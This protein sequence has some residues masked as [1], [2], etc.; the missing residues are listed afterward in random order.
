MKAGCL[1]LLL[2]AAS[3]GTA[4]AADGGPAPA[5][6]PARTAAGLASQ[7]GAAAA[8]R[9]R[10]LSRRCRRARHRNRKR[11]GFSPSPARCPRDRTA[12][13][14]RAHPPKD[15]N[16]HVANGP[17]D[18]PESGGPD[19]AEGDS[20]EE[21][22]IHIPTGLFVPH[23]H[24]PLDPPAKGAEE[25]PVDGKRPLAAASVIGDMAVPR[26]RSIR[27]SG[28][29]SLADSDGGE[30][31]IATNGKVVLFTSNDGDAL[32]TDGG[33]T[34]KYLDPETIFPTAAGGFCCDQVVAYVPRR[35]RWVWVL[36]YWSGRDGTFNKYAP[37]VIR[38]ATATTAQVINSSATAWTYYD[39]VPASF[40]LKK[41]RLSRYFPNLDRPHVTFTRGNA[42]FTASA[43]SSS[44][45]KGEGFMGT[46]VWRIPLVQLGRGQIDFGWFVAGSDASKVRGAQGAYTASKPP[47]G[48]QWFAGEASNSR[49]EV[50]E[51]KDGEG[52]VTIHEVDVPSIAEDDLAS[53][54]PSK[55]DWMARYGKQAGVVETGAQVGNTLVFGW[56]AGR[57]A[58]V[59][60]DD[61]TEDTIETHDQPALEFALIN[62]DFRPLKRVAGLSVEFDKFAAAL[63]Q[64]RANT[65]GT[66]GLSFA[67][68]GPSLYPSHGVAFLVGWATALTVK[69]LRSTLESG[70]D[71]LGLTV[72]PSQPRCFVAS[73]SASKKGT[74]GTSL[75]N[76]YVDPHYVLFGRKDANCE[77][78][79]VPIIPPPLIL[80]PDLIVNRVSIVEN[81]GW[82]ISAEIRND[83]TATAGASKTQFNQEGQPAILVDTPA[84]APGES[85]T[86][87]ATCVYGGLGN[88]VVTAD[89]SGLVTESNETNNTGTVTGGGTGGRCR[90]P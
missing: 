12:D 90:Y 39:F 42:Y 32:S 43:Y 11:R 23:R 63:P 20:A 21:R 87:T 4:L 59:I 37:N 84:L 24:E 13:L 82:F 41:I 44:L 58:K 75:P 45:T 7:V 28:A 67:Y 61:G 73:G 5:A 80:R 10:H 9:P 85:T 2:F 17:Y 68:G 31:S 36:Q 22:S 76:D 14:V 34:F 86:V 51:W 19:A 8:E 6:P 46:A 62:I 71:Y 18:P 52:V 70:N 64:V 56:M 83:G 38:V 79:K 54:D 25:S 57:K 33:R 78:P 72:D 49:L 27:T 30:S 77:P 48:T 35:K 16:R 15:V 89:V 1:A 60:R 47:I 81:D 55:T 29:S 26:N 74:P 40:G 88:A 66:L 50:F 3:I 53:N 65:G 69:G